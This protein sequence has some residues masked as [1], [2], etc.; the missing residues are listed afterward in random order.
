M[1][2]RTN[3]WRDYP[4]SMKR[5]VEQKGQKQGCHNPGSVPLVGEAL[6]KLLDGSTPEWRTYFA[7]SCLG[8]LSTTQKEKINAHHEGV[9]GSS[10]M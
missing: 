3:R 5:L 9:I 4:G 6:K 8:L 1:F 10:E 7:P 2:T